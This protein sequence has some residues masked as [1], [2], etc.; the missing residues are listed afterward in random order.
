MSTT[1]IKGIRLT[2]SGPTILQLSV[3]RR[4]SPDYNAEATF[5]TVSLK[6]ESD[7]PKTLPFD[8]LRRNVALKY[9]NPVTASEIL[10]NRTPP[11]KLD[12]S[13]QKL[14]PG[15]TE[16]F[17]VVFDY[18]AAIAP[19]KDGVAVL[20]FCVNWKSD[21]LRKS[22]YVDGA[23]DWNESFELCREVRIKDK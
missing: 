17:E 1:V 3:V 19:M 22:A 6:N 13:V 11:P 18:P 16:K 14:L 7:G 4:G 23:Y 21:W 20:W 15:K 8:E 10:D 9:R 5:F 2:L 12:G